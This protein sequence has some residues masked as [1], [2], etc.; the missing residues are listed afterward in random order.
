MRWK[1][2]YFFEDFYYP[3][4]IESALSLPVGILLWLSPGTGFAQFPD[5]GL[6]GG[7]LA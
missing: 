4:H 3:D 7:A 2:I 5:V 6:P 1:R